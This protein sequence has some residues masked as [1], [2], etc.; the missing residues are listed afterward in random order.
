MYTELNSIL[1]TDPETFT[2]VIT[3][4][5]THH[6]G[7][8]GDAAHQAAARTCLYSLCSVTSYWR[9]S[10]LQGEFVVISDRKS[11]ASFLIH[12][13]LSFYLRGELSRFTLIYCRL[14]GRTSTQMVMNR[15]NLDIRFVIQLSEWLSSVWDLCWCFSSVYSSAMQSVVC[16]SGAVLQPLQRRQSETGE[17]PLLGPIC[18]HF[19][20]SSSLIKDEV[21]FTLLWF[22]RLVVFGHI[23]Q[24]MNYILLPPFVKTKK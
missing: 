5:F 23:W 21:E 19:F 6:V 22:E 11:D 12:H 1:G 16:G 10:R 8:S 3:S 4:H 7:V 13:F 20:E 2:Q 18:I 9:L 24:L 15:W 14:A 17:S